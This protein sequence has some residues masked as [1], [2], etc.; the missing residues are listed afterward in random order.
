MIVSRNWL[1]D[2]IPF[3]QPTAEV[4]ERLTLAGLYFEF[5]E[6]VGDDVALDLEVTSNRADWLGHLGI[7]RE[8][9]VLYGSELSMPSADVAEL[10]EQTESVTSVEIECEDLCPQYVARVIRNVKV[11][12]SPQWL[13][14]RLQTVFRKKKKDG[15][16]DVYK[17]INNIVD[18]TN[19]VLMECGQ[20]LHAFDFDKLHGKRIV[21]RRGK[22]GE[23]IR[24]IDHQTYALT[25]EMCVIADEDRPVAIGGVMGGAETEITTG[26]T[27]VLIE[28]ANFSPLAIRSTAR[29]LKLHSPSS[30]RFERGINVQ[31]MDWAS[32]RCCEL[33]LQLA[34]GELYEEPV[35]A[36]TFPDWVPPTIELRFAQVKR[37]LGVAI[38]KDECIRILSSL[39]LPM[40]GRPSDEK[41]SFRPPSW[42]R[43]LTREID[44]IEEVARVAGYHRIPENAPIPVAPG[45][46]SSEERCR[47]QICQVF[48]AA[49]FD[50]ALTFSFTTEELSQ[51]FST[52]G[53]PEKLILEQ[54]AGAFGNAMRTTLLP[55][56]IAARAANERKG[57]FDA[58][59]FEISRVFLGAAPEKPETQ[60]LR[61]AA[62]SGRPFAELKGVLESL[63]GSLAPSNKVE[64]V[65]FE[66]PQL[67]PGRSAELKL[68]GKRWGLIGELNRDATALKSL[69]L[70]EAMSVAEVDLAPLVAAAQWVRE[71]QPLPEHQAVS[72]DFNFLL[73]NAV[74]WEKLEATIRSAAGPLLEQIRFGE[75]YRGKHIPAGK[76]SYLLTLKLR[77]PE[78]TLTSEDVDPVAAAIVAKCGAELGASLR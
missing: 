3:E 9:S 33:I 59:L 24:A 17:P 10:S 75:E 57:N 41:A 53:S 20:P 19:Y 72:R 39:G 60:P 40:M 38:P 68:D 49:G 11:G 1:R 23:K 26:T 15:T 54:N 18:I 4:G 74:T 13:I 46:K 42:R 45:Q 21:V 32:R 25:P 35:V 50:E 58:N 43:D 5:Q 66:H 2:Y 16:V 71:A 62:V 48:N 29:A 6:E 73:D 14:D 70:R 78:R 63:V 77:S 61:I 52:P 37:I 64:A 51:A 34:G 12:P 56:L 36:G 27:N 30:Y 76:K 22:P 67:L 44:L 28:V 55:S 47:N 65:P 31:Q 7:A 8:I 69:K